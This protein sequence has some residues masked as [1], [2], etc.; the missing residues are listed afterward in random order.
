[1][2]ATSLFNETKETMPVDALIEQPANVMQIIHTAVAGGADPGQLSKLLDLQERLE[3][4]EARKAYNIAMKACQ[5]EMPVVVKNAENKDNHARYS[6]LDNV[7]S[8]VKQ[9]FT[10]HGFSLS[11]G[12]SDSSTPGHVIV[13]CDCMHIGGHTERFSL[14]CPYDTT[15]PKGGATKTAIQGMGS[16]VSYGR[17]YLVY[18]IFN[19]CVQNE[20][21][22]GR[23]GAQPKL[24]GDDLREVDHWYSQMHE[25]SQKAFLDWIGADK[26][27]N[28]KAADGP[29]ALEMLKR[30][31][32]KK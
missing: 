27:E 31:V 28:I 23:A 12:S 30:K 18:M 16:A 8:T 3:K 22:D 10:K 24:S 13:T 26:L 2:A 5:E 1:M 19:L 6:T 14:N 11:F 15:G 4:N 17:R 20:D 32:N 29:K 21:D 9:T 25:T 7:L